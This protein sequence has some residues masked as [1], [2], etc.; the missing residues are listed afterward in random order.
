VAAGIVI[1][2]LAGYSQ[3]GLSLPGMA[4]ANPAPAGSGCWGAGGDCHLALVQHD[5]QAVRARSG[6]QSA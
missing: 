5:R 6:Q 4:Q 2:A 3:L 1:A